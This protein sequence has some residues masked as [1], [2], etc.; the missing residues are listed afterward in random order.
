[1]MIPPKIAL[2]Y[3]AFLNGTFSVIFFTFSIGFNLHAKLFSVLFNL[4][5]EKLRGRPGYEHLNEPLHILIEADLPA[6][7]VDM[8][9]RQAQEIIEELLKPVVCISYLVLLI[10]LYFKIV[11]NLITDG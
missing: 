3:N 5:E 6:S 10:I 7:V 9:L 1:M 11:C 8:R 4:K 2:K